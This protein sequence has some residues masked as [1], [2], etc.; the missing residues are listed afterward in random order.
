MNDTMFNG[1]PWRKVEWDEV[2]QGD[3]PY[4]THE[5]ELNLVGHTL[6][7]VQLSNGQRVIEEG[8]MVRFFE[9]MGML[10]DEEQT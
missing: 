7:V 3:L 2:P 1:I 8:D 6:K 10:D 5:G 9:A 4:V